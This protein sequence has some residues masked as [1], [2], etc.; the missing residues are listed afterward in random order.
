MRTQQPVLVQG[1][2]RDVGGTQQRRL[3]QPQRVWHQH[4]AQP[5][6]RIL[7]VDELDPLLTRAQQA[8]YGIAIA[9]PDRFGQGTDHLAEPMRRSQLRH[10][11]VVAYREAIDQIRQHRSGFHRRQLVGIADEDQPC[12]R[13]HASASRAI[14]VSDTIEVSSTTITL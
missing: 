5:R 13:A 6:R 7:V 14:S 4:R 10:Q 3:A 11:R 9:G 2:Q 12:A 8:Q 1:G